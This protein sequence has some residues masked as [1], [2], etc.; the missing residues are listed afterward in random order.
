M[1]E[2][3]KIFYL[4]IEIEQIEEA[5]KD[6]EDKMYPCQAL[7]KGGRS[8]GT[9][10]IIGNLMPEYSRLRD[11]LRRKSKQLII[12]KEKM[13]KFIYTIDDIENRTIV[14]LRAVNNLTWEEIGKILHCD[15]RTASRRYYTIIKNAHNAR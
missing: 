7:R 13:E 2:L 6:I 14:R 15:R 12:E 4:N 8:S 11:K 10:D 3:N 5:I 9:S 1:S